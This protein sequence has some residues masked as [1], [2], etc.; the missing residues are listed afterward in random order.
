MDPIDFA[1]M[2]K[3]FLQNILCVCVCVCFDNINNSRKVW[4]DMRVIK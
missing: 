2:D 3:N 1:Y 4:N